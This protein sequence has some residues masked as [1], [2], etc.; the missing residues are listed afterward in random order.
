VTSSPALPTRPTSSQ[1]SSLGCRACRATS[2]FTHATRLPDWSA[3]D[4]LAR[5]LYEDATRK[6]LPWNLSFTGLQRVDRETTYGK[7]GRAALPCLLYLLTVTH[8]LNSGEH[9]VGLGGLVRQ[10][11][12]DAELHTEHRNDNTSVYTHTRTHTHTH[13]LFV[14]FAS[15]TAAAATTTTTRQS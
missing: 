8:R 4:V 15:A 2:P 10:L 9:R 1:G 11:D 14:S 12:D 6:V 7:F 5:T 3:A 13:T